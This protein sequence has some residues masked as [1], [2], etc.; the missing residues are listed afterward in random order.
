VS[1]FKHFAVSVVLPLLFASAVGCSGATAGSTGGNSGAGGTDGGASQSA[2]G[3]CV[4]AQHT[5]SS[6]E[7]HY[8]NIVLAGAYVYVREWS[9]NGYG[10]SRVLLTGGTGETLDDGQVTVF[11][12]S[13]AGTVAWTNNTSPPTIKWLDATHPVQTLTLPATALDA[14]VLAIDA[15]E[16]IFVLA[17]DTKGGNT[18]WRYGAA[19][20]TFELIHHNV[21]GLRGFYKDGD[22]VAWLGGTDTGTA[23][24]REDATGG[25]PSH[26]ADLPNSFATIIGIDAKSIYT[27]NGSTIQAIDRT[28]AASSTAFD[29]TNPAPTGPPGYDPSPDLGSFTMDDKNFYWITRD[30]LQGTAGIY[31][32][33]KTSGTTA[34]FSTMVDVD[35]VSI[36]G[37]AVAY[38]GIT[39]TGDWGV[40]VKPK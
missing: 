5:V 15:H 17:D 19:N 27:V 33:A 25:A 30:R 4:T 37:C 9:P 18:V 8:T 7:A 35:N 22:S 24:Y 2:G 3:A 40:V 12:A 34:L 1:P 26:G 10:F 39:D 28:T 32:A 29:F 14:S 36:D 23:L 11:A 21:G 31:R 6:A 13:D 16:N 38:T 20:A